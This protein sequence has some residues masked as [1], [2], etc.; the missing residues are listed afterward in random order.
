MDLEA[1]IGKIIKLETKQSYELII[2]SFKCFGEIKFRE[3]YPFGG[4][5]K[6]HLETLRSIPH[7][8]CQT[9]LMS[10]IDI[11]TSTAYR[12]FHKSM[13]KL[14]IREI[15]PVILTSNEC[16]SGSHP[17]VVTTLFSD[18]KTGDF[19]NK[20]ST[21]PKTSKTHDLKLESSD[22]IKSVGTCTTEDLTEKKPI[23]SDDT[24]D[25]QKD[26]FKKPVF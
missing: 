6:V 19:S 11:I 14:K 26:F 20:M 22:N 4:K 12:Y 9:K 24:I 8:K 7:L 2:E 18:H 5:N 17:F 1:N 10:A 25:T 16:E 13:K 15:Q 23:C 3:E 21:I